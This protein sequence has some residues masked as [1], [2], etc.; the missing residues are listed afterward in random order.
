[1]KLIVNGARGRMG[2]MIVE[3]AA[4]AGDEVVALVDRPGHPEAGR[5]IATPWGPRTLL[6]DGAAVGVAADAAIDFSSPEASVAFAR[7]V[8]GRGIPVVCG[9]TG[10]TEVHLAALED[11]AAGAPVLWTANTSVGVFCLHELC[12]TAQAML[13][14]SYDVEIVEIHHRHKRDAPSGTA[15]SLS[16]RLVGD[17]LQLRTAREG[18]CGPR[19]AD[20]LGVMS[21]RGGEVVGEHTVYFFGDHDRIEITHRA[22]SR[23]IFAEGAVALA[24]RLIGRAPGLWR[25]ED[26]LRG[27]A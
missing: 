23:V 25:V 21:V 4:R 17:R 9:T 5:D 2:L 15:L 22:T 16:R 12:A 20:E 26:V 3:A 11:A 6:S 18:D 14:P 10:V 19:P 13:G 27:P 1:M 7:A 24:R 8:A